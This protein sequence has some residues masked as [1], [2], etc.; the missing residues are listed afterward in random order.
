MGRG[1][2]MV[3]V[4]SR[5]SSANMAAMWLR[6]RLLRLR[7][8]P[9]R[10]LWAVLA[11]LAVI[12]ATRAYW[13]LW[14]H[15]ISL[16]S[17]TLDFVPMGRLDGELLRDIAERTAQVYGVP[18]RL[19]TKGMPLPEEALEIRTGKYR[20]DALLRELKHRRPGGGVHRLGIT[21]AEVSIE[22]WN[23]VFGL[24]EMP[25]STAVMSLAKLRPKRSSRES[26]A[27]LRQR[28]V[29]IA[30]HELGHTFGFRH[31]GDERCVMSYTETAAGVDRTGETFC[32]KCAARFRH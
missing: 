13:L 5:P 32:S 22:D 19:A 12:V 31:C 23:F 21:E 17:A 24:A 29:K 28:A 1:R 14:P 25:G 8:P 27:L 26:D 16:R 7:I 2:A 20:A 15:P 4:Q 3:S 10:L 30:V 6:S 11:L 18:Y 9:A